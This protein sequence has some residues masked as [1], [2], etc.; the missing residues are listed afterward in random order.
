MLWVGI[1]IVLLFESPEC[2]RI[3]FI[4]LLLLTFAIDLCPSPLLKLK[5]NIAMLIKIVVKD[6]SITERYCLLI[7]CLNLIGYSVGFLKLKK[8]HMVMAVR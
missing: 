6:F 1:C 8:E 7:C 5:P 4:S 3:H 2:G